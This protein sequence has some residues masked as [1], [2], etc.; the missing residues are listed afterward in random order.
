MGLFS[1]KENIELF[2]L[3]Q[4]D[5][6]DEF[7]LGGEHP[8][9]E[10]PSHALTAEEV[11]EQ[12]HIEPPPQSGQTEDPL[13]ALRRRMTE[14]AAKKNHPDTTVQ[15]EPLF[16]VEVA[17]P[18]K[19]VAAEP[20]KE[21]PVAKAPQSESLLER[22]KAYTTDSSGRSVL[23]NEE[24]A[25][26]LESVHEILMDGKMR[27]VEMLKEK[28]GIMPEAATQPTPETPSVP[29][30]TATQE[31]EEKPRL[32][33]SDLDPIPLSAPDPA[34]LSNTATIRFTPVH[35]DRE[36]G[37]EMRVSTQTK[38]LNLTG[39]ISSFS[40]E[41]AAEEVTQLNESDFDSFDEKENPETTA[42][43]KKLARRYAVKKRTAFFQAFFSVLLTLALAAFYLPML[44]GLLIL[45]PKTG[46]FIVS[47]ILALAL[48]VNLDLF[49]AVVKMF[50]KHPSS[51]GNILLA[52]VGILL[53]G[54]LSAVMGENMLALILLG[55]VLLCVRS[56]ARFLSLITLTGN[57]R[58]LLSTRP[59]KAVALI[60]DPA[61]TF[62]MAKNSIEGDVLAAAPQK[63]DTV[64]NF[65]KYSRFFNLLNGKLRM[66]T[67]V[68]LVLAVVFGFSYGMVAHNAAM[69]SY[70]AAAVLSLGAL[71]LLPFSE[72]LPNF[73][74]AN[75][76]N[77]K[78]SYIAGITGAEHLE[79][80]N[81]IVL[82]TKDIFP[83]GSVTLHDLKVLSQSD[84]D[85]II[86]RAASLTEAMGSPLCPI[87][88]RIAGTDKSYTIPS[89]DSF[90][91]EK[92]LGISGWVDDQIMFIG[93]RTIMEA[94]GIAV[95]PIE[96]DHNILRSGFFPVYLAYGGKAC[97]LLSVQYAVDPDV[98]RELHRS[99]RAGITLLLRNCDPNLTEEMICDYF[100]LYEDSVK[101]MSN[102][103][104]NMCRMAVAKTERCSAPAIFRGNAINFM[105]LMNCASRIKQSNRMLSV[106]YIL[107]SCLG[108]MLFLYLTFSGVGSM[109]DAATLLQYHLLTTVLGYIIYWMKR[110]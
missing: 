70:I 44:S 100:G 97:A 34:V 43:L 36:G 103:G 64:A 51:D 52:E 88:K 61:V 11:V 89:S 92:D 13:A 75:R 55:G 40:A 107:A 79:Q 37:E 26:T 96:T 17:E 78:G 16:S 35:A 76:L 41:A 98:V 72:T 71:P 84:F 6:Q 4:S 63:T 85:R 80:A 105:M 48:L 29:E 21:K 28:Y 109:P 90:K 104:V 81:A 24:P 7:A 87:F 59:K 60:D 12:V 14:A 38:Q 86:L 56:I 67:I 82:S 20:T 30:E 54:V 101:I 77:K 8:K 57:L 68:S 45:S 83:A 18:V 1:K 62:A 47:G 32:E 99:T 23:D 46:M 10:A 73:S 15:E 27:T 65:M 95:P 53:C 108:A 102:A 31:P 74:A 19:K 110:P 106:L 69:G 25:Y 3:L 33:I 39:E 91:Y 66:V 94:H 2:Q 58:Q 50:G 9:A 22:C 5:E 42:D 49:A 93:N